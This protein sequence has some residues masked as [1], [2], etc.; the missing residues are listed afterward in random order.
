MAT[1]ASCTKRS[2]RR[3]KLLGSIQPPSAVVKTSSGVLPGG[4]D[5]GRLGSLLLPVSRRY[6]S[7]D[8]AEGDQS[9]A[10]LGLELLEDGATSF[11]GELLAHLEA[12]RSTS[13]Q[14]HRGA[15]R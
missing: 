8:G 7:S 13:A 6:R 14:R 1:P 5:E 12:A 3:R 9:L 2:M 10:V 11:D 15:K 4:S